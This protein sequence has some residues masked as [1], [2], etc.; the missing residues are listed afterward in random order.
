MGFPQSR[1]VMECCSIST[2]DSTLGN[3]SLLSTETKNTFWGSTSPS[4]SLPVPNC[5]S[6]PEPHSVVKFLRGV[7][8][9]F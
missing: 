9:N 8:L 7:P 4:T 3:S 2:G 6:N 5:S 1:Q